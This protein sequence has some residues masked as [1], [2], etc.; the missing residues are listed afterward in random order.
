ML[1]TNQA[2]IQSMQLITDS[3]L[4]QGNQ[5]VTVLLGYIDRCITS[6]NIMLTFYY[7]VI[8]INTLTGVKSYRKYW[9]EA[10]KLRIL[11]LNVYVLATLVKRNSAY[12]HVTWRRMIP[13]I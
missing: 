9:C 10:I 1:V 12:I 11:L 13:S 5:L 4:L 3:Q 6:N 8:M 7:A 2:V